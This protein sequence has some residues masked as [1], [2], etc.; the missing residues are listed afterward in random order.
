MSR[1][2][3]SHLQIT[4]STW[5]ILFN[6]WKELEPGG[7]DAERDAGVLPRDPAPAPRLFAAGSKTCRAAPLR[8]SR[9]CSQQI[10]F[11]VFLIM[12]GKP[13]LRFF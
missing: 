3:D 1:N 9:V 4:V 2:S 11:Y 5:V 10:D 8:Q 7:N 13:F 12:P 6:P